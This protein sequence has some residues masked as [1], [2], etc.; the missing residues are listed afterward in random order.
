MARKVKNNVNCHPDFQDYMER[1][2]AHPNYRGLFFERCRDGKIRW[3]VT[4]K[5]AAGKR[6][7]VWWNE[8]CRLHGIP[9][10][11]GCYANIARMLHPTGLHVCQCC[12]NV[13]SIFYEYPTKRTV[14]ILN[15][16]LGTDIDKDNDAERVE[17]TIREIIEYWC[18]DMD[19]AQ[20]LAKAFRLP[21]PKSVEHLVELVYTHLVA[22]NS[23]RFSPGVMCDPP[24]RFDGYHSYNL[25]CREKFDTGR[26]VENMQTYGQDRRAYEHWSDGDYNLAN[27]IM[28]E[29]RKQPPMRCP[30]CNRIA[31]M[32]AD[33]IGPISLGFSHSKN[34]K[35]MCRWCNSAK[36]NRFTK[37]DVDELLLIESSGVKVISWHSKYIWDKVKNDIKDDN[38]AKRASSIMAKCHQNVLSVFAIIYRL[39]GKEYLSRFLHPEYSMTDFRFEDFDMTDLG[40]IRIIAS[41]IDNKNKRNNQERYVRVS[42]ESLD[43]FGRKDNRKNYI[44]VDESTPE[45]IDLVE[46]IRR[47]QYDEADKKLMSLI[48]KISDEIY[49]HEMGR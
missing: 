39:T 43:E 10:G 17:Y 27:R 30:V 3:M 9:I 44:M 6:R 7:K 11:R 16:I 49:L 33:H 19:K 18:D 46:D 1:I 15:R 45:I 23:S 32:T 35:P 47:N 25:C 5:S 26:H 40:R 41:P 48:S 31:K 20:A 12:G 2:V 21:E 4:E 8:Q 42:F 24:D 13:K 29:F 36:N 28:G 38:D 22:R 37:S 34:F 14:P